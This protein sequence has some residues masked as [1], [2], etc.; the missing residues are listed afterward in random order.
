MDSGAVAGLLTVSIAVAAIFIAAVP[1]YQYKHASRLAKAVDEP[2]EK[3]ALPIDL[4]KE[5][6]QEATDAAGV[7]VAP[8]QEGSVMLGSVML[9]SVDSQVIH[10]SA[11]SLDSKTSALSAHT[12]DSKS[13]EPSAHTMDSKTPEPSAHTLDSNTSEPSAHTVDSKTPEPSAHT[14]DSLVSGGSAATAVPAA[15]GLSGS[16]YLGKANKAREEHVAT[17][18]SLLTV[19]Q[20]KDLPAHV[21]STPHPRGRPHGSPLVG[22]QHSKKDVSS[23]VSH[24]QKGKVNRTKGDVQ[25]SPKV[26]AVAPADVNTVQRDTGRDVTA[27]DAGGSS[28]V[29]EGK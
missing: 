17:T 12:L 2:T 9:G 8:P 23:D 15:S 24:V 26:G 13:L 22:E 19:L 10:G 7:L 4:Q 18:R 28:D 29:V 16:G 5:G 6:T 11:I 27:P 21:A 14:V 1:L 20:G 3:T 25:I